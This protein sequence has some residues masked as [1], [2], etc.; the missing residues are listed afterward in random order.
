MLH[1]PL[2]YVQVNIGQTIIKNDGKIFVNFS[3]LLPTYSYY[4]PLGLHLSLFAWAIYPLL[5]Q[6]YLLRL[7]TGTEAK[8]Y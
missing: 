1:F 3:I 8:V 6:N 4:L 5:F 7:Q 2:T